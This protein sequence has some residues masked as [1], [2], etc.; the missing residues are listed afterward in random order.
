LMSALEEELKY[1]R[2]PLIGSIGFHKIYVFK[3]LTHAVA[4]PLSGQL[5][6]IKRK[7]MA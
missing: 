4:I 3:Q 6:S 2:N 1:C 5:V 7:R